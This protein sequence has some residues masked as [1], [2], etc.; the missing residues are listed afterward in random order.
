MITWT[1]LVG[2]PWTEHIK[3]IYISDRD[4][5]D[6]LLPPIIG[7]LTICLHRIFFPFLYLFTGLASCQ[8]NI[9]YFAQSI[10]HAL[11]KGNYSHLPS[12][13]T[14]VS[15]NSWK[16]KRSCT[17]WW[18]VLWKVK[19][20]SQRNECDMCTGKGVPRWRQNVQAESWESVDQKSFLFVCL[21]VRSPTWLPVC[22]PVCLP[23]SP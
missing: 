19:S 6:G 21:S 23:A 2:K 7:E 5:L 20:L 17:V 1:D 13:M 16:K 18:L 11:T 8:R 22:L 3:E 14:G 12:F 15:Y 9:K 10:P 4:S